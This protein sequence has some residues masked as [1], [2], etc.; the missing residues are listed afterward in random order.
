[1]TQTTLSVIIPAYN[2]AER[3][4]TT[5]DQLVEFLQGQTYTYEVLIVENGSRD[6][7]LAVAQEYAGR[8]P[9]M[10]AMHLEGRGKGL[11]VQHGMLQAQG[12]YRFMCD[13]DLSMPI[14]Q[15][16]RF[17]PPHLP[18]NT[19]A[20]ASREA[21]GAVRYDEPIYRHLGGRLINLMIR[22]MALPGLQ[23]TQ[24]GF[25]CFPAAIAADLF[26]HMTLTGWSFDVEILFIAQRRGYAILEVAI[27]WRYQPNSKL[28]VVRA[29]WNL[30]TDLVGIRMKAWRGV[31]R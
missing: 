22:M 17:L 25:K 2:E 13:A 4:P 21:E 6:A 12:A 16:N 14:E 31:Y 28:N 18:A 5:L 20:I 7:T 11:A 30:F 24:C 10:R 3:L 9:F 29:T 1:M 19:I 15:L 27:P 8:Y 23:D 26:S